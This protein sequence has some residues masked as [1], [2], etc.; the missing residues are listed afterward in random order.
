M[1]DISANVSAAKNAITPFKANASMALGPV[2]AKLTPASARI[3]PPT[4]A[5]TPIPVA[6]INPIVRFMG[7]LLSVILMT[8]YRPELYYDSTPVLP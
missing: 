6:P 1:E 3:P 4:M 5:P 8:V 2:T 7:V